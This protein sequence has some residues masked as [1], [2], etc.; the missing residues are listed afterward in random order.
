MPPAPPVIKPV[1]VGVSQVYVVPAGTIS[2]PLTGIT[3]NGAPLHAT[4]V[5]LAITGFGFKVT[6]TVNVGPTQLPLVGVTV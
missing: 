5:L 1:T 4:A 3:L 6:T 2:D